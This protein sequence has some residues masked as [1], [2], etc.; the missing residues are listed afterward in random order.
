M[1]HNDVVSIQVAACTYKSSVFFDCVFDPRLDDCCGLFVSLHID[2]AT[3]NNVHLHY[4]EQDSIVV[5]ME[6]SLQSTVYNADADMAEFYVVK[7]NLCISIVI[8]KIYSLTHRF[9]AILSILLQY[10]HFPGRR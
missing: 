9:F 5:P 7:R 10:R 8:V 1:I 6:I 3:L 4:Y 2:S